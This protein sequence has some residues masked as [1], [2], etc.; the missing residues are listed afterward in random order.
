MVYVLATAV[1]KATIT[2]CNEFT[3]QVYQ[4]LAFTSRL[5]GHSIWPYV[6]RLACRLH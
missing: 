1:V 3:R 4:L 2:I 6:V 5:M